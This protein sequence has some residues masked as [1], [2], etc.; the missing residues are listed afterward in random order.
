MNFQNL[1]SFNLYVFSNAPWAEKN[2]ELCT[3]KFDTCKNGWSE[4][5]GDTANYYIIFEYYFQGLSSVWIIWWAFS[6]E[7]VT[8]V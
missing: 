8:H 1:L 3:Y 7:L 6:S 4:H 2:F 5:S